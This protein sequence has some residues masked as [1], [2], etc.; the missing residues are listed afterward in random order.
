M[1]FGDASPG[2]GGDNVNNGSDKQ[3]CDE[4]YGE[5]FAHDGPPSSLFTNWAYRAKAM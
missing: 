1:V 4:S 3:G 5:N 2:A